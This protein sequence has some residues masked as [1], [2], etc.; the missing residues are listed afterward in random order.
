VGKST[1]FNKIAGRRL[2]I[3]E[4]T[5]GVTRDRLYAETEWLRHK[6]TII[7]T[8]GLDPESEDILVKHVMTQAELAMDV[9]DVILFVTDG[10]SG[11]LEADTDVANI[12]RKTKKPVIVCA[13]KIDNMVSGL[14]AAYEFYKLGLGEPIPVSAAQGLGIGD[15]LDEIVKYFPDPEDEEEED[16]TI[17]VAVVGKPNV[18]KSSLINKILG[19][20]RLIVNDAP[21]TTRDAVD[22]VF[23]KD[24]QSYVFI[25]TAGLR[26]KGRVK[27]NVERYSAVRS[28]SAVSRS[29][30]CVLMID[31]REGISEQ[32]SKIAGMAHEKG[33]ASVIVVNKWDAVEK[34]GK[35]INK[36]M[37]DIDGELS[38]MSYAP[39]LF[40]SAKT[41]LRINK[42]FELVVMAY[43]NHNTRISTGV[44]NE[45]L[46]EA[47]AVT[48]PPSDKGRQLKIFYAT[49]VSVKPPTFVLFVNDSRLMHFSY[50]RYIE[51]QFR[52]AFGFAG[53][54][55]RFIIRNRKKQEGV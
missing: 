21:G 37:R 51:N 22:S 50:Q 13:N 27:E 12:L 31:A 41:G 30:V 29:N 20:E 39:K 24:G 25:D 15:L 9:A 34:D 46:M 8:G 18:G 16:D 1:L 40:I 54:P 7:D 42:L 55:I 28:V 48:Q 6:F 49:Q 53:T 5:P 45:V 47:T 17:R 44:L 14:P 19:E 10:K 35:T 32:D 3:V 43:Q 52:E 33:K 2:A 36:Y 38:F 23:E 26:K 11:P 4:D